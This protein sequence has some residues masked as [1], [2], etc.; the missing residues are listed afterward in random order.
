MADILNERMK[1]T[2][3]HLALLLRRRGISCNPEWS[4]ALDGPLHNLRSNFQV[5]RLDIRTL[6]QTDLVNPMALTANSSVSMSLSPTSTLSSIDE[7]F[8]KDPETSSRYIPVDIN[9]WVDTGLAPSSTRYIEPST[10]PEIEPQAPDTFNLIPPSP[11]NAEKL[12]LLFPMSSSLPFGD[13]TF[14][15]RRMTREMTSQTSAFRYSNTWNSHEVQPIIR[16]VNPEPSLTYFQPPA[17]L[18]QQSLFS[19]M[20][21]YVSNRAMSYEPAGFHG[22]MASQNSEPFGSSSWTTRSEHPNMWRQS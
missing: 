9:N 22:E 20:P 6:K 8:F 5:S 21:S 19:P 11:T 3:E 17:R 13:A 14:D 12:D 2:S 15:P 10:S 4:S 16:G 1:S 18:Q 7:R